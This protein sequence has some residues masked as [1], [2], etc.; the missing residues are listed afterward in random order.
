M[1]DN[2]LKKV[3]R[4]LDEYGIP[5]FDDYEDGSGNYVIMAENMILTLDPV[6]KV[7]FVS[8]HVTTKPD[9]AASTS[10]ILNEIPRIK[11]S[12]GEVFV[13]DPDNKQIL[14]GKKALSV[15]DETQKETIIQEFIEEQNNLQFLAI[16]TGGHC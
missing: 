9:D 3:L 14:S 16:C 7:I 6:I 1:S 11:I 10:L 5:V 13:Y 15:F 12:I 4:K 2:L 8:F